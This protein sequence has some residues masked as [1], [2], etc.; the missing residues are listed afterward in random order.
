MA[1][2]VDDLKATY[3]KAIKDFNNHDDA[4]FESIDE[5]TVY[6]TAAS[7]FPIKGKAAYQKFI[8]GMWASQEST[9][10]VP[11]NT[12]YQVSGSTGIAWGHYAFSMKQK[13]GP[14]RTV[15]GRFTITCVKSGGKWQAISSHYSAMPTGN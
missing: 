15:F 7:P 6:Y 4:T 13:D 5:A 8:K 1:G 14:A 12:Q 9:A 11:V 3:E 2:D 10:F